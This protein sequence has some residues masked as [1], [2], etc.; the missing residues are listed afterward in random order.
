VLDKPSATAAVELRIPELGGMPILDGEAHAYDEDAFQYFLEI[1]RKRSESSNR[2]FLLMLIDFKRHPGV[3]PAIDGAAART[4]FSALSKCV[5]ETD[6]IGWYRE[7]RVVGAVLTQ[8]GD[9][10]G[11]DLSEIIRRRAAAQ[12]EQLLPAELGRDLQLRMFLLSPQAK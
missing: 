5:R 12:L 3:E 7:G 8:H 4:L 1:E 2:P 6:F 10:D 11:G 9:F